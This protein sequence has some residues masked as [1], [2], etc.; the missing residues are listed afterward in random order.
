MKI[1]N[2]SIALIVPTVSTESLLV[3][4]FGAIAYW[5][6]PYSLRSVWNSS[7]VMPISTL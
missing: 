4:S 6:A 3:T 5:Q 1:E 2:F 7:L